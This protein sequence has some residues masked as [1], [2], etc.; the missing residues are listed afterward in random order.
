ML[1]IFWSEKNQGKSEKCLGRKRFFLF[2]SLSPSLLGAFVPG[3]KTTI[4]SFSILG[5]V[6]EFPV[7]LLFFLSL[8]C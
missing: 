5:L 7:H 4:S 3:N 6:V 1:M 8:Y 2:L